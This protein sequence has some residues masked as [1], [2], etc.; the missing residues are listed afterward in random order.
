MDK[1]EKCGALWRHDT[2]SGKERYTGSLTIA[3]VTT[4]IIVWPNDTST[5]DKRPSFTIYIDNF[6]PTPRSDAPDGN[7]PF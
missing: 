4:R 5:N 6:V 7:S 2:K 3:G 1:P